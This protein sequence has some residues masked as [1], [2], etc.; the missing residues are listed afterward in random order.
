MV[1]PVE[2]VKK[3][4]DF[5]GWEVIRYK[6]NEKGDYTDEVDTSYRDRYGVPELYTFG[7]DVV[8][9]IYLKAIWNP[10]QRVDVKV[11]H[12][13]L[14]KD[15]KEDGDPL[16]EYLEN[17]RTGYYT[18][19]TG[20]QQGQKWILA[21]HEELEKSQDDEIKKL[22][23]DYNKIHGFN[24]TYF[25][26][27]RIEPEKIKDPNSGEMIANPEYKGNEFHFFYRPFRQREY[28]VNYLDER[29]K[30]EVEAFFADLDLIST[31]GLSGDALLEA[32]KENKAKFEAKRSELE[33]IVEKYR[34]VDPE[35]VTNGNR[36]YDARNYRPIPGWKLVSDPQQQLFFD[37]NEGTNEFLGINGTGG[38]Q[39]FFYYKDVRVIEVPKDDPVPDGYV[40]VT[41][42]IDEEF[43]GG[44]F[45]DNTGKSVTEL[46][47]DVIEGL[48]SDLLPVPQE[49]KEGEEKASGKYYV[50]PD[51][52][53]KFTK[54]DEKP[55]LN[56]N[57]IINENHTFT[58]YFEWSG[59]TAR[60]LVT[61]ESFKDTNGTWINNFAP[62]I[63]QL[64]KQLVWKEKDLVKD[65]PAGT[66]IRFLD[67]KG[68]ELTKDDQVYNLVNEKK[69][70]D[71]D[72]LVRTVNI[73]VKA[74]FKDGKEPQEL[75]IPITVYKNVYEAL[76][77]GEK[78]LF[79]SDA[80]K[81]ELKDITGEYVKVTVNPT[82]KP[83]EK[84][85]KIYYVNP[86]AWV[87]IPEIKLTDEE[88][89]NLGFTN[90]TA[91]KDA[92]NENGI[93]DFDKRHKFTEETVISPGFSKDVVPQEGEDKPKVPDN[94]VKVIVKTTDKATS[95]LTQTFWVNPTKEVTIPVANPT[96]KSN[97]EVD[98]PK[99]GK[100]KVNYVFN[101]W[102]K[103]KAGEVEDSLT[104]VKPAEKID[105]SKNKYTDKVT[106]IEASY[107][108]RFAATPIVKPIKTEELHTPEGKEIT[109]KDLIGRI[110]PPENKEIE[111]ITVVE[112]PDP[113]KPG[114]QEAKVTIKYKD[115]STQGTNDKP[116]VIPV[117]VHKNIIPEAPGGQKPKDAL[118]NYVKVIFK[119]GEGGSVSGNLVYYVSP[120]VELDMTESAGK[121]TKTPSV[122]YTAKG[123][124]WSPEIKSEKITEEKTYEFNFVK[125]KD[126]VEK[127]DDP[128]Q[129]IPEGY[130]KVTFKTDGNGKVDDK[131]QKIYYVNPKAEITLKVLG[132]GEKAND[133][134]IAVPTPKPN[135]NYTFKEWQENIDENTPVTSERVH[136][137]IFQSGQVILTY[138]SGEGATGDAPEDVT[139]NYGTTVQ[140]AGKGSLVK[141]NSE[142]AGWKLDGED[143]IYQPGDSV[144]LEKARTVTAQWKP[145][146][147]TVTFD[148]KG[149]SDVPEQKIQHGGKLKKDKVTDPKKD[150]FVF[151]GWKEKDKENEDAFFNLDSQITADKTLVAQWQEPVQKIDEDAKVE[152]QFI[153]VTFKEGDHGKLKLADIEQDK[154]VSYKVA[155][156][157]DLNKAVQ[158]GLVVPDI[159]SAKYYK[160]QEE[161][162]GWDKALDLTLVDG[163]KEKIFTA[164]YVPE[165]DVIP[166][167]P[168]VTP[169][170]K[171]QEDKP[172]GMVL[173]T[174]KVDDKEAYMNGI[175]KYYVERNKEVKIPSPV[176]FNKIKNYEFKGW[177]FNH[178]VTMEIKGS[179]DKDT[180][181]SDKILE[182]PEIHVKVPTAG[183]DLIKIEQLT[184]GARGKLEVISAGQSNVYDDAK[185]EVRVRQGR[186]MVKK[187]VHG[188][189]LDKP[190]NKGDKINFWAINENGE[191]DM[192]QYIVR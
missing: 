175:T 104:E 4:Y 42:K 89:A 159:V 157:Y 74:T 51:E 117:E 125:L 86:K 133:K 124:T 130:I 114:K 148:T 58:A 28:T 165:A 100:K 186:R 127:T 67:E 17:K 162:A 145:V 178:E 166:I 182:K 84:D 3:G 37:L 106:V 6:K 183:M 80:E 65:L 71:K 16:V 174:F 78:P 123:G 172:E 137:A 105:L 118:D 155:K 56:A 150:G 177:M 76:T 43:K 15:C 95:D 45:T 66:T 160:A 116:V 136:V 138:K 167:D 190:L 27:Q 176:V 85:S 108:E 171:L 149:G 189:S 153:K 41:Y 73:K 29:G 47:Y 64:K 83:G 135:A 38:D 112:S 26:N 102:Q 181:I 81:G 12:H 11:T 48:K 129:V 140:L 144:K 46:H 115:G 34:V 184:E 33:K 126:I 22:Y 55:L 7:N 170:D 79:L 188:F 77:T 173:V 44:A 72:E 180:V 13:F 91:D 59:L 82:G 35:T 62:T 191:S 169:D 146:E 109:D 88:K 87:E 40:R 107:F 36:D 18:A 192:Y 161:N 61:T 93:Y 164:Q 57:T 50:T 101:Q 60:G 139:V 63:E 23:G 5:M 113:S 156:D 9:P 19:T 128:N 134:Q 32:N 14:D 70:A 119:A 25:Q 143:K 131:D 152:E 75:T 141:T 24:N 111:S 97:Q 69:A 53:K 20:D 158:A 39:L 21:P 2:P 122:G 96:G 110:T 68:N 132:D 54:W 90:W 1:K 187:E 8:S 163:E 49:L 99:L 151:M 120:E 168:E 103:V 154:P 94:F 52:G 30:A 121:V 147:H 142:F 98:I 179:F 185:I 92:Q 31:D 10:N